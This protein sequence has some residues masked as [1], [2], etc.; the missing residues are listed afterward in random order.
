MQGTAYP[1]FR[2]HRCVQL[3]DIITHV[4]GQ[5]QKG[6]TSVNGFE[7]ETVQSGDITLTVNRSVSLARAMKLFDEGLCSL[8]ITLPCVL[9]TVSIVITSLCILQLRNC[10][11][12]T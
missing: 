12:L 3:F 7:Q 11:L 5:Q 10:Q 2:R 4:N 8:N 9:V 6:S 1:Y